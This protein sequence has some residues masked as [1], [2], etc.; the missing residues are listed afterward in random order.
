[1]ANV[2]I[3][4]VRLL[5]VPLTSDYIHT[6]RFK[7]HGEQ[8]S[9]FQSRTILNPETGAEKRYTNFSYQRKD[10]I[11]RIPDHYDSLISCNYVMYKNSAYSSKWFYAFVT[12]ITYIDDGRTDLKIET[13][14][15]QTW[16]FDYDVKACFVER[17]HVDSDKIGEHTVPEGLELGDYI[18]NKHTKAGY[19][20]DYDMVI[21]VGATKSPD[22]K[23]AKGHLYNNIYSGVHYYTFAH[24]TE[25]ANQLREWLD[26]YAGDGAAEAITCMFLAPK[27]LTQLNDDHTTTPS[28]MVDSH[29]ING[30]DTQSTINSIVDMTDETL[31]GYTPINKKLL[32]SPYRYLLVSNNAGCSVPF[33]FEEFRDDNKNIRSPYFKIEGCICPGTSIR[34]IP[35]NYKGIGRNDEEGINLGKFPCLNWTS[36]AY[37]NWLTQNGLNIG[38][39]IGAS[40]LGAGIGIASAALAPATGG[41]SLLAGAASLTGGLSG[42][43]STV[44]EVRAHSMQPPQS[45][46]NLNSGDVVTATG[47]NDFHFYDM[48]IKAEYARIIDNYFSMFGY[49]VN[50]VKIPNLVHREN[51]WYTK[52]IDANIVGN[53]PMSDLQKI[54]EC[55]NK[56]ITF[57]TNPVNIGN[58]PVSNLPI[59]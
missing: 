38:T 51:Y 13:D 49:K 30:S 24:N 54:K 53:I 44:G 10:N 57:W 29:Y 2:N 36:D 32:T 25:G 18:C 37:T 23:N 48:S 22:G 56:G 21:V 20:V 52:T 19:C 59:G 9:Y 14:V 1:M 4:E 40:V 42:V 50:R 8:S 55:Y 5:N 27:R 58:Y 12:D 7:T 43:A 46:G 15:I 39:S 47:N 16:L 35:L 17:E 45:S 6:V 26:G 28:N 41:M 33:H 3:T 11:I 34:L 31:Q